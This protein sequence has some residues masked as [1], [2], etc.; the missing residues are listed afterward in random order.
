MDRQTLPIEQAASNYLRQ[1]NE[2]RPTPI[3]K[4]EN[5]LYK[6]TF[7]LAFDGVQ[8]NPVVDQWLSKV[9]GALRDPNSRVLIAGC[10]KRNI[11]PGGKFGLVDH[12][13]IVW[14]ENPGDSRNDRWNNTAIPSRV[15]LVFTQRW[16]DHA[17]TNSLSAQG[18]ARKITVTPILAGH[19]VK[20][21]LQLGLM[22]AEELERRL[23]PVVPSAI[24]ALM[25]SA[26]V[27]GRVTSQVLLEG[28]IQ[29][30]VHGDELPAPLEPEPVA[31][32]TGDVMAKSVK[33]EPVVAKKKRIIVNK[34]IGPVQAVLMQNREVALD[35]TLTY[36]ERARRLIGA[37]RKAGRTKTSIE[38]LAMAV[39]HV[40]KMDDLEQA[41]AAEAAKVAAPEPVSTLAPVVE[42][43]IPAAMS[44]P[45]ASLVTS[46]AVQRIIDSIA[47]GR[48]FC[49]EAEDLSRKAADA[50]ALGASAFDDVEKELGNLD[51]DL[52]ARALRALQKEFQL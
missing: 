32:S 2:P 29:K 3:T 9:R 41:K 22:D 31:S 8:I 28:Q 18:R 50:Y 37:C 24:Q 47:E 21:L 40:E 48:K 42:V 23:R 39:A 45:A 4:A 43:A 15:S 38:S 19:E 34:A 14:W 30:L 36:S 26:S 7:P 51:N 20:A 27:T 6:T 5:G 10:Q 11:D 1:L 16:C 49:N 17:M 35:R 33:S 25:R 13:R 44:R 46:G 52:R 12:P